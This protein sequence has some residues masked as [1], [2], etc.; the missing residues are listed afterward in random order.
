MLK[1]VADVAE[2]VGSG[3]Q[4]HPNLSLKLGSGDLQSHIVT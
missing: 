4:F 2:N 3:V 1:V